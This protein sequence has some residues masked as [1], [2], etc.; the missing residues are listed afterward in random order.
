MSGQISDDGPGAGGGPDAVN[1]GFQTT[2]WSL[3]LRAGGGDSESARRALGQLYQDYWYPLYA[4]IRRQGHPPPAAQDAI[5]EIFLKLLEN[6]QLAMVSPGKGR[7]RS[8]LLAAANHYLANDWR[9][10]HRQKRG[11]GERPLELDAVAAEE[12]YRYEPLDSRTPEVL[13]ERS[14]AL[15]VLENV[16][17]RLEAEWRESGRES[18]FAALRPFLAGDEDVPGYAEVGRGVG[19]AEGA[20]RVAVHRLRQRYRDLL[21]AEIAETVDAP[22]EV[23]DE[24]RHLLGVLRG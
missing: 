15:A 14:W 7:F 16:Y 21:R 1:A 8:Y 23:E 2:R 4:H 13:F 3:V 24:L 12:R 22:G 20:T 11:G 10:R 9:R 6:D 18:V 19:L 17:G 5:Q